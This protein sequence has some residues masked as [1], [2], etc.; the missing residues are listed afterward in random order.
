[1]SYSN[2][3]SNVIKKSGL[4]L[5]AICA[6]C[7]KNSNVK[8][9]PAYLSKLQKEGNKNPASN[10]VNFAIAKAC[11]IN[12]EDLQFEADLERAPEPVKELVDML[13]TF[14]KG[15]FIGY[16][17]NITELPEEQKAIVEEQLEQYVNMGT[18][19]FIQK[20]ITDENIDY[21]EPLEQ[22]FQ[23]PKNETE[24]ADMF[25]RLSVGIVVEDNSMFPILPEGAKIEIERLEQ[26]Q[27]GDIVSVTL[28][29]GTSLIRNYIEAGQNVILMPE[30][31]HFET[32][33]IKKKD[34]TIKGR[35]KSYT[36]E[37]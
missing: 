18:R 21:K 1:M 25:M 6:L 11:R 27:N 24:M 32:K 29:D 30:N 14:I 26:Y 5:R 37:L 34:I 28:K 23:I 4:S 9:S 33:T 7:E 13:V 12:P 19:E 16:E 36:V 17:K 35:V 31:K 10:K 15:M 20:V 3:L 8:I 22:Q 2:Y